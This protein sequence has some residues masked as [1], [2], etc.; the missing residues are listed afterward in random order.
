MEELFSHPLTYVVI[1]SVLGIAWRLGKW[2]GTVDEFR[3]G[4][5]PALDEIREDIKRIFHRLP[6]SPVAGGS[7]IRLTD[8]GETLSRKLDAMAWAK[9]L[10]PALRE[11]IDG[12]APYDLQDYCFKRLEQMSFEENSGLLDQIRACAFDHGLIESQVREVMAVE[13]RDALLNLN[14]A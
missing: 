3:N 13:S 11:K 2:M 6:G 14:N 9:K 12:M 8:L 1:L 10:A 5:K 7:P 4:V